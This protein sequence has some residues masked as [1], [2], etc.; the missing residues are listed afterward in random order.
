MST[1]LTVK[2]T[3]RKIAIAFVGVGNRNAK[4]AS[5]YDQQ[6]KL[7]HLDPPSTILPST[8]Y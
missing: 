7:T 6:T 2:M 8:Q 3:L 4:Q 5:T 1:T